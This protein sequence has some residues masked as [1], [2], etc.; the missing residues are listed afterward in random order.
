MLTKTIRCSSAC[1]KFMDMAIELE[2]VERIQHHV[3][4]IAALAQR[5]LLR[6]CPSTNSMPK[7]V[8]LGSPTDGGRVRDARQLSPAAD[9]PLHWL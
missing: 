8:S 1:A 5:A 2:Q 3:P 6:D 7:Q 4:I 9:M